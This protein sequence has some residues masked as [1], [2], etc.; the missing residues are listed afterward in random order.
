MNNEKFNVWTSKLKV[1][2]K[3]IDNKEKQSMINELDSIAA[4]FFGLN[5]SD[6]SHIFETFHYNW[7]HKHDLAET[8]K[9][10][11]KKEKEVLYLK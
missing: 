11:E 4:I 9:Y 5:K 8:L 6:I 3:K 2:F 10:F 7:N 1:K